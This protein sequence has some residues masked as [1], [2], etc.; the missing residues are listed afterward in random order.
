MSINNLKGQAVEN[1]SESKVSPEMQ[2]YEKQIN[3]E[4]D[5]MRTWIDW[6]SSLETD[7]SE[8]MLESI[9]NR[10]DAL[11]LKARA[12]KLTHRTRRIV[13]NTPG[14]ASKEECLNYIDKLVSMGPDI[15][16]SEAQYH[17]LLRY[18]RPSENMHKVGMIYVDKP[19][20][21]LRISVHTP[22]GLRKIQMYVMPGKEEK[23]GDYWGYYTENFSDVSL[24]EH[25]RQVRAM[26]G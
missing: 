18:F 22:Q 24:D 23:I 20:A 3:L 17:D 6:L 9:E 21:V 26:K 13:E 8:V 7:D 2:G 15:M 19:M 12:A 25:Y 10:L 16:M 14:L 5:K 4:I 1:H 11:R